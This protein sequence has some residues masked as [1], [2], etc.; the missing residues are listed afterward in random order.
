M[1]FHQ[2]FHSQDEIAYV[3]VVENLMN[4]KT[5]FQNVDHIQFQQQTYLALVI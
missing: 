3:T 5:S 1:E 2:Q 4:S